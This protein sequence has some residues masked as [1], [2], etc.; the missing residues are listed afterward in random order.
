MAAM[1]QD[2]GL[3]RR[4]V[5]VHQTVWASP[6][7]LASFVLGPFH[8]AASNGHVVVLSMCVV[9]F[10][11][12]TLLLLKVGQDTLGSRASDNVCSQVRSLR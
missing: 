6:T 3:R 1:H 7:Y 12:T 4:T 2:A 11:H 8:Y 9:V 10:F 5:I